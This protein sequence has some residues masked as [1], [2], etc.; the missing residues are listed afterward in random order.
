MSERKLAH[1]QFIEKDSTLT[2]KVSLLLVDPE[3]NM[4][5]LTFDL[6]V[7]ELLAL[8]DGN[9]RRNFVSVDFN[10]VDDLLENRRMTGKVEVKWACHPDNPVGKVSPEDIFRNTVEIEVDDED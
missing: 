7:E 3:D 10:V 1:W 8:L 9:N 6:Y 5:L 4:G 2:D